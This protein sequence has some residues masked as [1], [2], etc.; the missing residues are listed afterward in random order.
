VFFGPD[1]YRFVRLVRSSLG[2]LTGTPPRRI[3]DIGC[4]SGAD[5]LCAAKLLG[6]G[7]EFALADI[8]RKALSY[9][10]ANAA[11]NYVAHMEIAHS[12]ILDGI[13]GPIDVI[14]A[15]PPYLVDETV[16]L[17]ELKAGDCWI[18]GDFSRRYLSVGRVGSWK[19]RSRSSG[20]ECRSATGGRSRPRV[21]RDRRAWPKSVSS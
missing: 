13:K 3:V 2:D 4:G 8:N 16:S 1:T 19:P 17:P 21:P 14:L 5:G 15:N 10:A 7:R 12:D 20:C 11:I 6:P 9:A 18:H